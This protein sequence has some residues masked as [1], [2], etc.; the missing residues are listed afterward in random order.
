MSASENTATPAVQRK[1]P[2]SPSAKTKNRPPRTHIYSVSLTCP[3]Q[4]SHSNGKLEKV[5]ETDYKNLGL[6]STGTFTFTNRGGD[7]D[8]AKVIAECG[9]L[10]HV[11]ENSDEIEI[12]TNQKTP[13]KRKSL[14]FFEVLSSQSA[15]R[16]NLATSNHRLIAQLMTATQRASA[17]G[18]TVYNS[19]TTV[20]YPFNM[21]KDALV[22]HIDRALHEL[23]P[24]SC[25]REDMDGIP[26]FRFKFS[27]SK[28]PI[29][30][31]YGYD[32]AFLITINKS[33]TKKIITVM[34][35]GRNA[36]RIVIIGA[37]IKVRQLEVFN[38]DEN[39]FASL[40]VDEEPPYSSYDPDDDGGNQ[41]ESD[42]ENGILPTHTSPQKNN[43][44]KHTFHTFTKPT[45]SLP[46]V[47]LSL[48]SLNCLPRLFR[49]PKTLLTLPPTLRHYK[50]A[51]SY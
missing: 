20:I 16:T 18:T 30:L 43:Y 41:S 51:T 15:V 27:K 23:Q 39:D 50:P 37:M 28:W 48:S 44:P 14:G 47:C 46:P 8:F 2:R 29:G 7:D 6:G 13:S 38:M 36:G 25:I 31:N 17:Q 35:D 32:K 21:L 33:K 5:T 49:P 9:Y 42:Q 1:S 45:K 40:V 34:C 3:S 10:M 26:A 24:E 11:D 4:S 22:A 19:S 12:L